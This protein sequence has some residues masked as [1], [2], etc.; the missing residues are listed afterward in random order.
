MVGAFLPT[1]AQAEWYLGAYGGITNPGAFSNV[2]LSSTPLGGG[3]TDAHINDLEL[4]TDLS[5][6]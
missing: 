1:P 3:V 4:K 6:I 5:K 2:T